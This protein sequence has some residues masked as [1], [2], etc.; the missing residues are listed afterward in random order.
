MNRY[1]EKDICVVKELAEIDS[2]YIEEGYVK[3]KVSRRLDIIKYLRFDN[4]HLWDNMRNWMVDDLNKIYGEHYF[5]IKYPTL[6]AS[7]LAKKWIIILEFDKDLPVCKYDECATLFEEIDKSFAEE[8][9]VFRV[10]KI[11]KI[12]DDSKSYRID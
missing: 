11:K 6:V 2:F 3:E 10:H 4:N 5:N 12:I 1:T 9:I 8:S 7:P